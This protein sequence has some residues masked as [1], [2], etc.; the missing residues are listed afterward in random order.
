[1]SQPFLQSALSLVITW[2]NYNVN[3]MFN[4]HILQ[5][6]NKTVEMFLFVYSSVSMLL[7]CSLITPSS[8]CLQFQ[9]LWSMSHVFHVLVLEK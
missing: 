4:D 1:M 2:L 3:K 7:S 9:K 6:E 5:N 8:I